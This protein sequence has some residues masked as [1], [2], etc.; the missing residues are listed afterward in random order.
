MDKYVQY[1]SYY[2]HLYVWHVYLI[3][4]QAFN[5]FEN[6]PLDKYYITIIMIYNY[7]QSVYKYNTKL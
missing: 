6:S 1:Y 4:G 3:Q 5:F 7:P 2:P